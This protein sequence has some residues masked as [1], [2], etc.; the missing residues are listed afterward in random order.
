MT[1]ILL[2]SDLHTNF[3]RDGGKSTIKSLYEKDVDIAV[4]AGD[5]SI[6]V[7]NLLQDNIKMFCDK[8]PEV[9][10][11][12]GN[13]EYY[14]SSFPKVEEV[15]ADLQSSLSNFTWLNN[16]RVEVAGHMFIGATLWFPDSVAAQINKRHLNDY[17]YITDFEPEVYRRNEET[18]EFFENNMQQGDIVVTHHMPSHQCIDLKFKSSSLNCFFACRLD[19]LIANKKPAVW[20]YGHTHFGDSFTYKST[21]LAANPMGY[22]GENPFF[23]DSFTI[24]V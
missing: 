12:S 1:E 24:K 3:H 5:L 9:V 6:L 22:P 8:Y 14:H 19:A 7:S 16:D 17:R 4:V 11:V 23:H 15:L 18:V 10:Y 21:Q 2:C 20:M 13:H